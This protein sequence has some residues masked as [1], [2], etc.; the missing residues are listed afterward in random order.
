MGRSSWSAPRCTAMTSSAI[1]SA[2]PVGIGA[3]L[4]QPEVPS[5][6]ALAEARHSH[7]V[8]LCAR[9]FVNDARQFLVAQVARAEGAHSRASE[10]R[11]MMPSVR[12]ASASPAIRPPPISDMLSMS[13]GARV[14]LRFMVEFQS[15]E[16]MPPT[17]YQSAVGNSTKP[18]RLE[19]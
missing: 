2:T 9:P 16:K 17:P 13:A 15:E 19:A 1:A 4:E 12:K 18:P 5:L 11:P 3:D 10:A 14:S 7:Y 8:G 6:G